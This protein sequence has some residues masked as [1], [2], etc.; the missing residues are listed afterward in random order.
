[1]EAALL[2]RTKVADALLAVDGVELNCKNDELMTP[3]ALAVVDEAS[4]SGDVCARLVRA[5]AALDGVTWDKTPLMIASAN[6][7][8]W[9]VQALLE[10]GADAR[11][12][13]GEQMA[14]L[15]YA[16]YPDVAELI[17]AFSEGTMLDNAPAPDYAKIFREADGH[18]RAAL[19]RD[20]GAAPPLDEAWDGLEGLPAA[21]K[22]DFVARGRRFRAIKARWRRAALKYH[23]DKHPEQLS[24]AARA[25]WSAK[26]V[27]VQQCWAAL[28]G[29]TGS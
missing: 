5:G 25:E 22:P 6:G 15:D 29:T 21:W 11:R 26:F 12:T 13:N 27:R 24:A 17:H 1:M 10:L 20:D 28:L 7:H 9:A 4:G 14:A 2:G 8:V 18:R 16:R 19:E 3:L 23:P